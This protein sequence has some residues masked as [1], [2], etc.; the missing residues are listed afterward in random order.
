MSRQTPTRRWSFIFAMIDASCSKVCAERRALSR[1]MFEQHHRAATTACAK[2]LEQPAGNQREPIRLVAGGVTAGMQ[3]D[4]HESERLGAI[5]LVA[6]RVKRLP[7]QRR[8]WCS[9]G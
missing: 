6:H 5:D 7:A 8:V 3:D 4:A 2:Q 1:R 9:P